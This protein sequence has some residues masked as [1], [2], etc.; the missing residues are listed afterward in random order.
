MTTNR[1]LKLAYFEI[2]T[3]GSSICYSEL[4]LLLHWVPF[5]VPNWMI[6]FTVPTS[7][8]QSKKSLFDHVP[9]RS[10]AFRRVFAQWI[11]WEPYWSLLSMY[12]CQNG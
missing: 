12:S 4:V 1:I 5:D 7:S 6:H 2:E 3:M 9:W 11:E 8:W 10:L